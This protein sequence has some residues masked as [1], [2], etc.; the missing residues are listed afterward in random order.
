MFRLHNLLLGRWAWLVLPLLGLFL[1][2]L[3]SIAVWSASWQLW[4]QHHRRQAELALQQHDL[5]KALAHLELCLEVWPESAETHLLAARTA[6]RA[7]AYDAAER[8]LSRCQRAGGIP[9]A[10]SLE[11]ALLATQRGDLRYQSYLEAC[12]AR[13][14]PDTEVILE[15]LAAGFFKTYRLTFAVQ[16]LDLWLERQ[17]DNVRALVWRGRVKDMLNLYEEAQADYQRAVERD[18]RHFEARQRLA[19]LL[20]FGHRPREALPHFEELVSRRPG[21]PALLLGLARCRIELGEQE[22]A[23]GLL[24]DLLTLQPDNARALAEQGKLELAAGK[25][26]DAEEWLRRAVAAAPFEREIVYAFFQCLQ[27]L[28]KSEEARTLQ[29]RLTRIESDLKRVAEVTREISR[30]PRDAG[31]RCEAGQILLRNG[32][33]EEGLRWLN[34]ALQENPRHQPTHQA[35]ADYYERR[36]RPDLGQRHR[37]LAEGL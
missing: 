3:I 6:R 36:G 37:R 27:Q 24:K 35:L 2:A 18:P 34:S 30:Q 26:T 25:L 33:E 15:A 31:L 23:R 11:R 17:P 13:H 12:I 8:H 32:Q 5:S 7:N 20:L 21:E 10:I 4:A 29:E 9:E 16:A 14:H 19:E 22:I 1:L 28:G